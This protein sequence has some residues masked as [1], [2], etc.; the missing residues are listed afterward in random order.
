[1]IIIYSPEI[2]LFRCAPLQLFCASVVRCHWVEIG[3]PAQFCCITKAGLLCFPLW[4]RLSAA[5]LYKT[6]F[7][8]EPVGNTRLYVL[9]EHQLEHSYHVVSQWPFCCCVHFSCKSPG[10]SKSCSISG[11]VLCTT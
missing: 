11:A 7:L 10:I 9:D 2:S 3:W 6:E 8:V 5:N 4:K 1:M